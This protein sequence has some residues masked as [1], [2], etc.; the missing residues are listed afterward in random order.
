MGEDSDRSLHISKSITAIIAVVLVTK[1]QVAVLTSRCAEVTAIQLTS[2]AIAIA[3]A[4]S[5][6]HTSPNEYY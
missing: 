6:S 3:A 5:V 2:Y 1:H 4:Q